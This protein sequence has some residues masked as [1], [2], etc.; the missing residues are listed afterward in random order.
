MNHARGTPFAR[1]PGTF[2]YRAPAPHAR[3][4]DDVAIYV[5][6]IGPVP[7]RQGTREQEGLTSLAGRYSSNLGTQPGWKPD[8]NP[9][10]LVN[11]EFGLVRADRILGR[12]SSKR[13]QT[14]EPISETPDWIRTPTR[15]QK[16]QRTR[17]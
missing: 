1:R 4:T 14:G 13:V 8:F 11:K 17:H 7:G 2:Q 12:K 10:V 16:T 3:G 6:E 5:S 15:A 9:D